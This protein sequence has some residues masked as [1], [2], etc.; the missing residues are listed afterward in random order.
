MQ[1]KSLVLLVFL[2]ADYLNFFLLSLEA[3]IV[4]YSGENIFL[5]HYRCCKV[6]KKKMRSFHPFKLFLPKHFFILSKMKKFFL[7]HKLCRNKYHFLQQKKKKKICSLIIMRMIWA[8]E[9]K[10][11]SNDLINLLWF[12]SCEISNAKREKKLKIRF[13]F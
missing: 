10:N 3:S 2:P 7:V 4:L 1:S 13:L 6:N 9:R 8:N 11:S 12:M 5:S